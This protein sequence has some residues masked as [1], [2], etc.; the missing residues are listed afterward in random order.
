M[1]TL[2]TSASRQHAAADSP[3]N[4][5]D[6]KLVNRA[7]A[8]MLLKASGIRIEPSTLAAWAHRRPDGPPFK[9]IGRQAI[10]RV[11]AVRAWLAQELELA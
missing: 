1:T 3:L 5:D 9:R 11:S 2:P 8:S 10:Y 7:E 6:D 4:W